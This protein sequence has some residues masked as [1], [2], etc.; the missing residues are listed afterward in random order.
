LQRGLRSADVE[1]AV[2]VDL[3]GQELHVHFVVAELSKKAVPEHEDMLCVV[4]DDFNHHVVRRDGVGPLG[5][6]RGC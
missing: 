5:L 6:P 4:I 3:G 1:L 2:H